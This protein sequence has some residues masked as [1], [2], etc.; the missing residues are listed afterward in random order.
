MEEK[1]SKDLVTKDRLTIL[2][3]LIISTEPIERYNL[4]R[5]ELEYG[6]FCL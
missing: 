2:A 4:D 5:S 1:Y 6:N 3:K